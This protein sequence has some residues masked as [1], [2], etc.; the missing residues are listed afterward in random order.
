MVAIDESHVYH[1]LLMLIFE[2][3]FAYYM[4][5][6]ALVPRSIGADWTK[7]SRDKEMALFMAKDPLTFPYGPRFKTAFELLDSAQLVQQHYLPSIANIEI[8]LLVLHGS[9][10][11]TTKSSMSLKMV[12]DI[13]HK[14]STLERRISRTHM[15]F[16]GGV[17]SLLS[18]I[19]SCREDVLDKSV[20]WMDRHNHK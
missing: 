18:D 19:K 12:N 8:P 10:D 1:P 3:V 13:A 20:R 6:T 15:L 4:P 5:K 11:E 2:H 14:Q 9:G 16:E 17:H 7:L